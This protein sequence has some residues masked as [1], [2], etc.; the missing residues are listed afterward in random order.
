MDDVLGFVAFFIALFGLFITI[1]LTD[2]EC[3]Q[4]YKIYNECY[5]IEDK[6]YC[7]N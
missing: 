5:Q 6:Y 1:Q 4:D 3:K 2:F 7:K